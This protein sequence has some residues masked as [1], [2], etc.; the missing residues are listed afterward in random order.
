MDEPPDVV[1][2]GDSTD[3]GQDHDGENSDTDERQRQPAPEFADP[4][5]ATIR[6]PKGGQA[7]SRF[8]PLAGVHSH[9]NAS[10]TARPLVRLSIDGRSHRPA[11]VIARSP[12]RSGVL[13]PIIG[14]LYPSAGLPSGPAG[15]PALEHGQDTV[16]IIEALLADVS[17][18]FN[19]DLPG[20]PAMGVQEI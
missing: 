9:A 4:E 18:Q 5:Y 16:E 8:L 11:A 20:G 7:S 12:G 19:F 3:R 14:Q 2:H 15:R 17:T 1:A 6:F 10:R 13:P